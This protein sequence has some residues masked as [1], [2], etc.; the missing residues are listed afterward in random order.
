MNETPTF[1]AKILRHKSALA[2]ILANLIPLGGVLFFGWRT[3]D[4]VFVFWMENVVIGLFNVAKMLTYGA[5]GKAVMKGLPAMPRIGMMLGM[6]FMAGFFTVHYGTFCFVHG[7]F[8]VSLLGGSLGNSGF[9][10]P[11]ARALDE[12]MGGLGYAFL[13]LVISHGISFALNY[14]KGGEYKRVNPPLLMVA[15]YGRIV[16][17]HIAILFGAFISIALGSGVGILVI[18]IVGKILLDLTL[19]LKERESGALSL[20]PKRRGT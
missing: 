20:L 2:L 10:N 6:L 14:L 1:A 4:V 5:M 13:A 17:L 8:V 11:F 9:P 7:L 16:I 18:L 3:F 19:H 12:I 15:P